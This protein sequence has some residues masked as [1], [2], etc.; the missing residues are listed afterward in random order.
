MLYSYIDYRMFMRSVFSEKLA[1]NSSFSLRAMARLLDISPSMLSGLFNGKRNLSLKAAY[2]VGKKLGLDGEELDYFLLLIDYERTDD[3]EV[4][5]D[6]WDRI[7]RINASN[8]SHSLDIDKFRFI[9][10]W[11]HMPI[12]ELARLDLELTP[13]LISYK[14][15]I[16]EVEAELA[17]D[18]LERLDLIIPSIRGKFESVDDRLLVTSNIPNKALQNF[19]TQMLTKGIESMSVQKDDEMLT[20]TE[21]LLFSKS[22]VKEVDRAIDECVAKVVAIASKC[23]EADKEDVYHLNVQFFNLTS[24]NNKNIRK[25]H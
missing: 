25:N 8:K 12:L 6:I 22:K 7:K 21:T 10:D 14:L 24:E 1:R 17:L 11:Y 2:I 3:I 4:K 16:S 15:G 18:R 19:H 20:T 5:K 13:Q 23:Q 9:S